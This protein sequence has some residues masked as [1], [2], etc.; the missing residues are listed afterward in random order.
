ME[1]S[2]EEK[3]LFEYELYWK[4]LY[5]RVIRLFIVFILFMYISKSGK[6]FFNV[7]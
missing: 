6:N 7:K 3:G 4:S 1:F 2:N 5:I